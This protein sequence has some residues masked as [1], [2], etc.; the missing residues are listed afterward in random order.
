[1][2]NIVV[3]LRIW[4]K[5]WCGKKLILNTDNMTVVNICKSGFSR[6]KHLA[7]FIRNIWLLAAKFDIEL[8][9]CHIAGQK[10]LHS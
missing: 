5:E 3:A 9:V 10:N 1:M 4:G 8:V 6:D 7:A 2:V